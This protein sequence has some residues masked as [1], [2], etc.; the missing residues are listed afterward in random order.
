M[1]LQEFIIEDNQPLHQE[2]FSGNIPEFMN[3]V[4]EGKGVSSQGRPDLTVPISVVQIDGEEY[5][6]PLNL[7]KELKKEI[8]K[9]SETY[10]ENY[11]NELITQFKHLTNENKHLKAK[12]DLL[13]NEVETLKFVRSELIQSGLENMPDSYM[14]EQIH[15]LYSIVD[16]PSRDVSALAEIMGYTGKQ[17]AYN[18]AKGLNMVME[19]LGVQTGIDFEM[20][21]GHVTKL[22]IFNPPYNNKGWDTLELIE[23]NGIKMPMR[24]LTR[25]GL[26]QIPDTLNALGFQ[27]CFIDNGRVLK[28]SYEQ[29]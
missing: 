23:V 2:E 9:E 5:I 3:Q 6:L 16:S 19:Y 24:R 25:L 4:K 20:P 7:I 17:Q 14:R 8:R 12:N 1:E 15:N 13:S 22:W 11:L 18:G 29:E 27:D 21:D 26:E 28:R 10:Q